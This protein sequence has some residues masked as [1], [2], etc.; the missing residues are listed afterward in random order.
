MN[1]IQEIHYK[2]FFMSSIIFYSLN[3]EHPIEA[4]KIIIIAFISLIMP[5]IITILYLF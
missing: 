4:Q 5:F 1:N 3:P 2:D